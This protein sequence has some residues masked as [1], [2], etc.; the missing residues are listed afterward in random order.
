LP[1]SPMN[2]VLKRIVREQSNA[3]VQLKGT[4]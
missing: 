3:N 2:K 4:A 1:R